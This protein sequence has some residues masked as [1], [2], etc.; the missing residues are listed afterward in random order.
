MFK[1]SLIVPKKKRNGGDNCNSNNMHKDN[2]HCGVFV[3]QE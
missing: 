2:I 3:T 1:Q